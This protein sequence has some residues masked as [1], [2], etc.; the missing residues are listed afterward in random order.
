M[1][2]AGRV[3][4][5]PWLYSTRVQAIATANHYSQS[6]ANLAIQRF[7]SVQLNDNTICIP[8]WNLSLVNMEPYL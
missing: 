3:P 6:T 7:Y 2:S 1:L 8:R 5:G 4:G